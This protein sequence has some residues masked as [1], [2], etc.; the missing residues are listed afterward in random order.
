[1][2]ISIEDK[3][4]RKHCIHVIFTHMC[5]IAGIFYFNA[6]KRK[7]N[8][9]AGKV[10][11]LL[12][13]R[14][15]D[16]EGHV[17]TKHGALYHT[18]LSIVDTTSFSA[19]P[20][21][22]ESTNEWLVYNGEVFNY[23]DLANNMVLRSNGDVEVLFRML[24]KDGKN[25]LQVINGFFGFAYY[26]ERSG[27]LLLARDRYGK[28]PLY[29]FSDEEKIVFASEL[30]PLLALTGPQE[31]SDTALHTYFRLNYSAGE[32][33]IFKNIKRL[34]PG[35]LIEADH[36]GVKRSSWYEP[37]QTVGGDL[38]TLLEDAVRLRL[39]A[40]VPVGAFLSGGLDSS[41]I[42]ALAIR[43]KPTL[44]TFS[45][46]FADNPYFDESRY[47]AEVAAHIGSD[48]QSFRLT[49]DDFLQNIDA[50]LNTIDE[51]FA[52]SSAFNFYMLS[53][54]TAKQ[55]KVALSG[56][57]ADELFKGYNKHRALEIVRDP[58][59]KFMLKLAAPLFRN[60][61]GGRHSYFANRLRQLSKLS[62]LVGM[63]TRAAALTLATISDEHE[64]A[65]LLKRNSSSGS[66]LRDLFE[67]PPHLRKLD[68]TDVTDLN[69][70][71]A[72][73]MLVKADRFSMRHG[74][75]IRNPFLDYRV[76]EYALS[77]PRERKIKGKTQKIILRETFGD[78]LPESV[79]TRSKKGFELPLLKW[80]TGPLQERVKDE[81]LN[82]TRIKDEG[83]LDHHEVNRMLKQLQSGSPGDSA[84]RV[85]AVI[86]FQQWL[87]NFGK[88]IRR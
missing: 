4:F 30:K 46:G 20:Y 16:A 1:M 73:D 11:A 47:A 79:L 77:L 87:L 65:A 39:H 31:I 18:R 48:H 35:H 40:D 27:S 5:G 24:Q 49:E 15:P 43:H 51:P 52:D 33:S 71:L 34:P 45:I 58:G 64:V 81:W 55:V 37:Q 59:K 38:H 21:S 14:G 50:F 84:A 42:A 62:S 78:L 86:V 53:K 82:E 63:D 29:Y 72:D 70:V 3:Y 88:N 36:T 69:I 57:G 2:I 75:E 10:L 67:T 32:Q 13:H 23:R 9:A 56:D 28:K 7:E 74:I 22:D 19:Q 44:K 8:V 6:E 80:L 41:I 68:Q 25:C 17:D 76:V 61:K 83:Y 54:L 12:K 85:W 66:S 26:N 60:V